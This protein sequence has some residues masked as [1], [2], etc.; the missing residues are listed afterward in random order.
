MASIISLASSRTVVYRMSP[1]VTSRPLWGRSQRYTRD[2][3]A[4]LRISI[5]SSRMS[6]RR[7]YQKLRGCS[8]ITSWTISILLGC[9]CPCWL[10]SPSQHAVSM[11]TVPVVRAWHYYPAL[12]VVESERVGTP[13]DLGYLLA[14]AFLSI[15]L[16]SLIRWRRCAKRMAYGMTQL[17]CVWLV[18]PMAVSGLEGVYVIPKC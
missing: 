15:F 11:P 14:N 3:S 6:P 16:C 13:W 9:V 17:S 1:T 8:P 18:A 5:S 2:S 10:V 12:A 4:W 7:S